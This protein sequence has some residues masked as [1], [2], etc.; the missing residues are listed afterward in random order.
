MRIQ[1]R[2]WCDEVM[3]GYEFLISRPPSAR[4][5]VKGWMWMFGECNCSKSVRQ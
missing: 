3:T 5:V 1:E 2:L 4:R